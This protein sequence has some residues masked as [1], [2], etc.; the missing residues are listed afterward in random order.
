MKKQPTKKEKI[1]KL[2]SS[3][4]IIGIGIGLLA[5]I[6]I[7]FLLQQMILMVIADEFGE[8][9][10]GSTI[11]VD[12][13]ETTLSNNLIHGFNQTMVSIMPKKIWGNLTGCI[14]LTID[15]ELKELCQDEKAN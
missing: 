8:S 2:M 10:E 12:L 1:R 11:T 9:L 15:G 7:G 6:I 5:G 14:N 4:F 13:N 3:V